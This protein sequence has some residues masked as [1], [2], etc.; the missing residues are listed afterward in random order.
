MRR[1][2]GLKGGGLEDLPLVLGIRLV[3]REKPTKAWVN[4]AEC[5]V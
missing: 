1:G 2:S 3:Y 4:H 5:C